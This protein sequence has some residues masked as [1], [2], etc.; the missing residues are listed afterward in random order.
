MAAA[1]AVARPSCAHRRTNRG[2]DEDD[3]ANAQAVYELAWPA[4]NTPQFSWCRSKLPNQPHRP[5]NLFERV[6]G[7]W[8]A[9]GIF[10]DRAKDSSTETWLQEHRTVLGTAVAG[11]AAFGIALL[12]ARR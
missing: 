3:H 6:A 7:N 2:E 5:D 4:M 11:L 8:S 1:G 10:D 9:H 12:V